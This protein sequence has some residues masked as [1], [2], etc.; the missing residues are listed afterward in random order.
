[1]KQRDFQTFNLFAILIVLTLLFV[2]GSR[3]VL[4]GP[5]NTSAKATINVKEVEASKNP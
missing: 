5:G 4:F 3:A 1:M 2:L